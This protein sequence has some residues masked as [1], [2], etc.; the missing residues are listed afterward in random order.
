MNLVDIDPE[1]DDEG[2]NN[3]FRERKLLYW[4][5]HNGISGHLPRC[6]RGHPFNSHGVAA[7]DFYNDGGVE[8]LVN[9]SPD[10]PA[11]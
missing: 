6:R 2:L 9:N 11:C 8:I 4:S 10:R 1:L 3:T 7:A 5:E